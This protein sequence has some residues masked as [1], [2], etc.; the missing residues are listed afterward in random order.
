MSW[1]DIEDS[2]KEQEWKQKLLRENLSERT[3]KN[4]VIAEC[5]FWVGQ[6]KKA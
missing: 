4:P 6:Y 5:S 2:S 3:E 1:R